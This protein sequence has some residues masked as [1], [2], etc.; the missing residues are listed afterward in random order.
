[1]TKTLGGDDTHRPTALPRTIARGFA[2][3]EGPRW[4]SGCLWLADQHGGLIHI[5][6]PDGAHRASI[7]IPGGPSGMGWLPD[8]DLLV[9]S[10]DERRIYRWQEGKA[11]AIHAD[12]SSV[13]PGQSNDMVVDPAGRAYVGNVGFDYHKGEEPRTTCIAIV[14]M[15][16][17][18]TIGA[19]GLFCPNG[20]VITPDGRTLIVAETF[21]FRLTAFDIAPDG[22]LSR[23]RVF[24]D[25]SGLSP[26][27]ICL[28][29]EGC[30]WAAIA[31]ER[32]VV[33]VGDGGTILDRIEIADANPYAC[34][35]GGAEGR[36][37]FICC[38]PDHDPDIT[39]S[40]MGGRVDVVRVSVG[41]AGLP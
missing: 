23:R 32:A 14:D 13:H 18:V 38:A 5:L 31:L 33:R 25:L 29:A 1:M 34:M 41:G 35:L 8:G 6:E 2:Y 22:T 7:A 15:D 39:R 17:A 11:L 30:V 19:D 16:G 24:A 20:S 9:V 12:L 3:P 40:L 21:A 28:D 26:D 37:L 4:H 36:D 10:M 27:G